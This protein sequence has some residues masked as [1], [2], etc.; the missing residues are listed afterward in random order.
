MS[1]LLKSAKCRNIAH[2]AADGRPIYGW[3]LTCTVMPPLYTA[4]ASDAY[5]VVDGPTATVL[6]CTR[7]RHEA[8]AK[9]GEHAV[10]ARVAMAPAAGTVGLVAHGEPTHVYPSTP[11]AARAT[12]AAIRATFITQTP[13]GRVVARQPAPW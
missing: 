8:E 7:N 4:V 13:A 2:A 3:G 12:A 6:H 11:G 1:A 9:A 10:V 5:V